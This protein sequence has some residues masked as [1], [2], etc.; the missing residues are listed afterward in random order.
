MPTIEEQVRA[1]SPAAL[2]IFR[3]QLPQRLKELSP[4]DRN[5]ALDQ[6]RRLPELGLEFGGVQQPQAQPQVQGVQPTQPTTRQPVT[7]IQ[8]PQD[9]PW[10]QD[11]LNFIRTVEQGAGTFL[12]AP[13]TPSVAGTENLP[14]W[15]RERAEY[16][17]WE[18]PSV[19]LGFSYPEW[20]GGGEASLGVKGALEAVPWFATALAT[21]GL[22]VAA[23]LGTKLG[24]S[25][26]T[27]AAEAGTRIVRPIIAVENALV[28]PITK[29]LQLAGRQVKK[30]IPS[31]LPATSRFIAPASEAIEK[32][33]TKDDWQRRVAQMFGRQPLFK[34]ITEKIGGRA[35]SVT[36]SVEDTTARA[37]LVG[38]RV[39][40]TLLSKGQTALATLR[41]L[42][43]NPVR[44]F[45]IDEATG[46]TKI[47][48]SVK[49]ASKHISDIAEHPAKY[50]LT[51]PQRQYI[52]QVHRVEAWVLDG[53]K[54][55]GIDVKLLKFDD[56]SHWVHRE[57][58][59]KNVDDALLKIRRGAGRIGKKAAFEKTRFYETAAEGVKAG[60]LYE[61]SLERV[62]ELYIQSAAKR[63]SDQRI[64][65][66]VAQFG[67]KPLER[68]AR[69]APQTLAEA[70]QTA[71]TLVGGRQLL[72]VI[73]RAVRGEKL[74]EATL[75]AQERRFP[76][77]GR[78]LREAAKPRLAPSTLPTE[79]VLGYETR[80]PLDKLAAAEPKTI[81]RLTKEIKAKGITEP[82]VIRVREDGSTIVW[83]GMHR[84]IVA[85][86]LGISDIPI[87]YI[88]EVSK[89][90]VTP[91]VTLKA[92][93]KETNQI[94]EAAKAPFFKARLAR[95]ALLER[96]K[97]PTL[98]TEATIFHPAFQ[99]KIYPK[100]VA[101]EIQR[102][103]DDVGFTPLNKLAT[104]SGEMRTLVA[105]AD[106][107][108]MFIQGLPGIALHP[109]AWGRAAAK[110]FKA[111][112]K[113]QEYQEYLVKNL[114][115][116]MQRANYG[117]YVGG[118]EFMEAMPSLQRTAA[119]ATRLA[120]RKPAIGKTAIR[121]TYGRFEASFGAFGDVMR[122][123]MWK[124][125][126]G[127]AKS[128]A[129]LM[130]IAR[131]ID[132]MTGVM[133]SKGLGLG[134]TQRDFEQAFLFF[135]PRYTRAGFALV[136]DMLKGGFTGD[137]AR[138]ALGSMMAA[139]AVMYSGIAKALGQEP[140]FDPTS[141]RFMTIEITDPLTGTTRHFGVGGM[142][143][144]FMRFGA[145]V[146]A[147]ATGQ[148]LNEP[149][150]FVKMNR[151][152]NPFLKF[153]FSK[154]APLT[155][156]VEG[157][158]FGHNYFGEPFENPADYA[159]FLGEQ[160]MPIA[161]QS[162]FME[163]EGLSPTAIAA[164]ELGM[165]TFP[166][167][168]WEKRN[169]IRDRLAQ[170]AYGVDW[171]EVGLQYGELAQLQ[172][173]RGSPELQAAT[174]VATETTSKMVRGEGI[175]W[176]M[177]RKEGSAIEERYR[178]SI[179]TA[180]KEFSA[181]G[182]GTTFREKADEAS[183]IRRAMYSQRELSSEYVE[184]NQYFNQPL[185][186]DIKMNPKD[187]AR[188]EYY[189]LMYTP[190]MYD[191]FGNYRF[192]EADRREQLFVQQYGKEMLDYVEEYMGA[193][194]DEPPAL[195]A[196]K[197]ARDVLKPYWAVEEQ[198]WSQLPQGL[199]QISD[200]IKILE[201]TDPVQA[202][203]RLF[204]YPQIVFARRQIALFKRQLK[205]VSQDITNALAMFYRF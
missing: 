199:K 12:A 188:R 83:D 79:K 115:D 112:L 61:P 85:K 130:E 171:R 139:G 126:K 73:N 156:F 11:A 55:A 30:L 109:K 145:D 35:A 81:A 103:W 54:E 122:N 23:N 42:H 161:L 102:Y 70:R 202:K 93:A 195:Q 9:V 33:I 144:S 140:N 187:V 191:Q 22:G 124:G 5:T 151:F 201:R 104:L 10:W 3:K 100:N 29:P 72:K 176:D 154:S 76:E 107:S 95:Q 173:E 174:E 87:K 129:D 16:D 37:L 178:Q 110:S 189:Q 127:S 149:L 181:I 158:A 119:M 136:G 71:R 39:Q 45:G 20:L 86:N 60:I 101:S 75:L 142:M 62:T 40:E 118:F 96:A 65:G 193:K 179:M 78:R 133:S 17:V 69:I 114:D 121:Q 205:A 21:A 204:S 192:D 137:Q 25:G 36:T 74:P 1:L 57:V 168:D 92:L 165:R 52:E 180:S 46:L 132:R 172:L 143:T 185:S 106:F 125:L 117:G 148:G 128:E 138:K 18:S 183:A 66:M 43:P 163:K 116:L 184:I 44:L 120:L 58:I 175:V 162:A 190:D 50:Q 67:E 155:G 27:R 159:S 150:D 32:T 194:W 59:G 48:A 105:A 108:A 64:A 41:E 49:G 160:V 141:G 177:W 51:V 4:L 198:V 97:T 90:Q 8:A 169:N 47:R 14:W 13:F 197:S 157:M 200:Q 147:S 170:E 196:L 182:D 146:A 113:P 111:F 80:F 91:R 56:F 186:P 53:L 89:L 28:Y 131:H 63:I 26:L 94:I 34:S 38:V 153:M 82:I 166:R 152:D 164:E 19:K 98:G 15:Q 88:G 2:D 84:L 7:P 203:R 134:K 99:G 31:A 24:V 123:E 135:A 6:L 77:L 167:S 68:A